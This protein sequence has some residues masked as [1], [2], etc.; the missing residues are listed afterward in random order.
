MSPSGV[1]IS[2]KSLAILIVTVH[3]C[4]VG[5]VESPAVLILQ[6]RNVS[7]LCSTRLAVL[8]LVSIF[9]CL[10][11]SFQQEERIALLRVHSVAK[12]QP[13]I[14]ISIV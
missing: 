5:F 11:L 14:M 1:Y 9:N 13:N 8:F 4:G 12:N 3:C 6:L 7:L 2:L 10:T